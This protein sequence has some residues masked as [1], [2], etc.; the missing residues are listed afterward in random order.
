MCRTS[1]TL[2]TGPKSD[3]MSNSF[4]EL[5][6]LD[7]RDDVT[8]NL[9]V[10]VVKHVNSAVNFLL[11]LQEY[12]YVEQSEGNPHNKI[13]LDKY[14]NTDLDA[15]VYEEIY[16]RNLRE[17]NDFELIDMEQDPKDSKISCTDFD[18][19]VPVRD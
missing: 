14:K 2:K 11:D 6:D 3:E 9:E 18:E 5:I 17:S 4:F 15:D 8:D 16:Q 13:D 7:G 12:N 1:I 19:I 10:Q